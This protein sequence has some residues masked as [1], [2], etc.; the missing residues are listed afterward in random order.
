MAMNNKETRKVFGAFE[1]ARLFHVTPITVNRWIKEGKLPSFKTAGGH[2]RVWEKDV[3]ALM[4][5]LNIAS[6]GKGGK[7]GLHKVLIVEDNAAVRRVIR[8]LI[9]K[10]FPGAEIHEAIDG[11]EAGF[12]TRDLQPSL[13]I[14]DLNLPCING[15]RVCRMIRRNKKLKDVKIL[16]VTGHVIEKA[17]RVILKAGADDFLPKP[18]ENDELLE[19]VRQLLLP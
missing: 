1:I 7:G 5:S 11:Y 2:Y 13:V 17:R 12:K 9:E 19:R 8:R 6:P 15:V 18:F 3:K 16:A 4:R 14:L 10:G